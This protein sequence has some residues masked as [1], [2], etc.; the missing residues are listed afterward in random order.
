[1]RSYTLESIARS[2][3]IQVF[4]PKMIKWFGSRRLLL[5]GHAF[6]V[7]SKFEARSYPSIFKGRSPWDYDLSDRTAEEHPRFSGA[8]AGS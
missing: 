5:A 7:S 3:K 8:R 4:R 1:M 2:F 6:R